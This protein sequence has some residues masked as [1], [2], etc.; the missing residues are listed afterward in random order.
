MGNEH[1]TQRDRVPERVVPA[2]VRQWEKV[3][4]AGAWIS[5]GKSS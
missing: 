3:G 2:V 4:V 5:R 1:F